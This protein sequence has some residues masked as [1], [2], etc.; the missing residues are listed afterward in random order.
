M[1][2]RSL[3][4]ASNIGV[5]FLLVVGIAAEAAELKVLSAIGIQAVMEDLMPKFERT[6][7]HKLAITFATLGAAVK[8][9][10]DGKPP[11]S[12]SFPG[13]GSTAS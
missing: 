1:K 8:H 6:S 11:M 12:S 13:R 3:I 2:T 10:Q 4:A 7:G 5:M 9:V